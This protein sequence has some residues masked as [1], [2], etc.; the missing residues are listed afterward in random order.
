MK[1]YLL[2]SSH[3]LFA[4]LFMLPWYRCS[5]DLSSDACNDFDWCNIEM[6]S[7]SYFHFDP[8]VDAKRWKEAQILAANGEQVRFC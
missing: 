4:V 5:G 8:P 6:P 2:A 1:K 7:V 3:I